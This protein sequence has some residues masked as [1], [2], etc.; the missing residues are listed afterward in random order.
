MAHLAGVRMMSRSVQ[1]ISVGWLD[2]SEEDRRRAKEY[3]SQFNE[4]NTVDELGFGILRDAFADVFFPATS[5]TMTRARYLVFL[6]ALCLLVER[7]KRAGRAAEQRLTE[8]ENELRKSLEKQESSGVIGTV[9]KESLRRYPSSVYWSSLRRLG[10]FL[11]PNWGLRYYQAHLTDFYAAMKPDKDDDEMSHLA[12]PA[13][14]NWDQAFRDLLADDRSIK[15]GNGKPPATL[16]FHLTRYEAQY[17]K[18]KFQALAARETRPSII[19]HLLERCHSDDFK[20][21][22]DVPVPHSLKAYVHHARCFSMFVRGATL[23]YFQLLLRERDK[24][25]IAKPPYDLSDIFA[26]WWKATLQELSDW[27]VEE[28]LDLATGLNALR[29]I[30]DAM[31]IKTWLKLNTESKN[32]RASFDNPQAHDLI[33]Q[34]ERITRPTKSRLQHSEYLQRWNPPDPAQ[35]ELIANDPNE[36][37]FGLNYRARI[38]SHVCE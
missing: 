29:R 3:L 33:H 21:P 13:F 37:R 30:N 10:I 25:G 35:I 31:F 20:Y 26:R 4:E 18:T 16:N 1:A 7:E 12:S 11:H 5:T 27:R 19:S 38:G 8:L 9:A 14:E 32:A 15:I 17:L 24:R 22:W 36:L 2:L 28:F 6:P 34:R 23:Q